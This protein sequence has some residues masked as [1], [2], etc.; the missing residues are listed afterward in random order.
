M[1]TRLELGRVGGVPIF[2]DMFLVLILIVF[3]YRYFTSGDSQLFSAGILIVI[4]ILASILLHEM[5]HM[6]VARLFKVRTSEIEIGGLGGLAR[7]ATSLPNSVLARAAIYLA[8]PV[9]NLGLWQGFEALSTGS[10]GIGKPHL[11]IAMGTL[12]VINWWLMVFNM[13][14][15]FPLDGGRTLEALLG[16]LLGPVWSI[17]VVAGLGLAVTALCL[18]MALPTNL[19]MLLVAFALFQTNWAALD[20]VGGFKGNGRGR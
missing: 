1:N 18:W 3:S 17:R 6:V 19:W 4:G 2:L 13:L 16:P 9:A 10:W 14:P 5:G 15:S 20:S 8:G 7:F 11:A 12:G